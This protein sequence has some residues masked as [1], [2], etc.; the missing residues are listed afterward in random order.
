MRPT[1]SPRI[2]ASSPSASGVD[3]GQ[4]PVDGTGVSVVDPAGGDEGD[5]GGVEPHAVDS[6]AVSAT[7]QSSLR[8]AVNE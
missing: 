3:P 2:V 6:M 1:M 7:A 4:S 5:D 8:T